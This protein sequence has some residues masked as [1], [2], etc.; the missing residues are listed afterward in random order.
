[1]SLVDRNN[2]IQID[3]WNRNWIFNGLSLRQTYN[4]HHVFEISVLAPNPEESKNK[5]EKPALTREELTNLL[6][7]NAFISI[8]L[9][10]EKGVNGSSKVKKGAVCRFSGF[11][12]QVTPVWTRKAYMLRITGYSKTIFMDC[13]PRFRTFYQKPLSEIVKKVAGEYGD[14]IPAIIPNNA[15]EKTDFSVQ[16]QE[17][18][19]RYLCRLADAYGKVFYFDGQQLHF[20]DLERKNAEPAASFQ[21]G[22]DVKQVNLSLNIAP[23]SFELKA[24][25]IGKSQIVRHHSVNECSNNG[26]IANDVIKKS[27]IYPAP[28]IHLVNITSGETE[29]KEKSKRLLAKQAQDLVRITG[30]SDVPSLKIGSKIAIV[31]TPEIIGQGEFIVI[32]V[33]H[34][35]GN[36]YSYNNFF[37]AIPAGY[38]FPVRMQNTRNPLC[39]PLMAVV[40]DHND[41]DKIGRVR[42][43]FI[44]DEEK[45]LSPWLRVLTPY[46]GFGGMYFLPEPGDQVVV[47]SEDFNMEKFPFVSG[48]FYHGKAKAEKWYDP[49]NKKKGFTTE[50]VAFEID[51]RTGK[52]RIEADE[53]EIVARKKMKTQ[54]EE[55]EHAAKQRMKINGG[56]HLEI[57]AGRIDLN[58]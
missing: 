42:V 29:L 26:Q 3:G 8:Q 19:Y 50:K 2:L 46:T 38:P 18:D 54:A 33:S 44:G 51:D 43:E 53:I 45:T 11:V 27:G 25:E 34:N 7:K 4:D 35:V 37:T 41:P 14:Q 28:S 16:T 9:A 12:D 57:K 48:A 6:G 17:T 22:E 15:G 5:H 56:Q 39:G 58:A 21:F 23:L 47:E 13:G 32:E 36:D 10:G 31:G 20:G 24:Y 49:K 1:M 55:A 40:R 52:L 30:V